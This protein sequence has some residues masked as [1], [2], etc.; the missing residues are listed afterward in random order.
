MKLIW[1]GYL[2]Y[3][4]GNCVMKL[5]IEAGLSA[6]IVA[7]RRSVGPAP[8]ARAHVELF[9]FAYAADFVK[10]SFSSKIFYKI[11]NVVFSFVFDKYCPIMD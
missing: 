11:D 6:A 1:L 3:S 10:G 4:L 2:V 5:C 9:R 8:A 7:G